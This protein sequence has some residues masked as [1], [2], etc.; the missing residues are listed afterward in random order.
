LQSREKVVPYQRLAVL[1]QRLLTVVASKANRNDLMKQKFFSLARVS[2]FIGVAALLG[3][4]S[5]A[6]AAPV[7]IDGGDFANG[8]APQT[9]GGFTWTIDPSGRVFEKKTKGGI[10][11]VGITPGRTPG[12]IDLDET[13]IGE[14]TSGF[15]ITSLTL[16]VL[17]DGPEFGDKYEVA[18]VTAYKKNGGGVVQYRLTA[19]SANTAAWTGPGSVSSVSLATENDGGVWKVT[20]PF[21][22]DIFSKITFTAMPDACSVNCSNESDFTLVQLVTEQGGGQTGTPVP[23]PATL[24]LVGLA[25]FGLAA[26]R[27]R[28]N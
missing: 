8:S 2:A 13:L 22:N 17:Y 15:S 21:G 11:G 4:S 18:Q 24:A 6:S 3:V 16:G 23:E 28:W 14:L 5:V 10:T 1:A 27:R 12:E 25:L 20:N 9:V 26:S 7:T 19:T